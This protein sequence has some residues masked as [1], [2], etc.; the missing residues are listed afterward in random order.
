MPPI[1]AWY[2]MEADWEFEIGGDAPVID[3]YWPGFVDLRNDVARA[4]DLIECGQLPALADALVRLNEARSPV[5]TSKVDLFT[6]DCID[7]YELGSTGDSAGAALA[8][9]IDLLPRSDQQWGAPGEV[10]SDCEWICDRLHALRLSGCRIDLVIR[11]AFSG[12]HTQDLGVTAYLTAC[13]K[14][15]GGARARLSECLKAF[16]DTLV[17][18]K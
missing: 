17:P 2:P 14:G 12:S 6:P 11:R 5:W 16:V 7:P 8:C 3:A 10:S 15:V 18:E 9:Y 1:C 4:A 13:S